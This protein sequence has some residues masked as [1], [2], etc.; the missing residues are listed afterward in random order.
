MGG[1]WGATGGRWEVEDA[2][3]NVDR[4]KQGINRTVILIKVKESSIP[5]PLPAKWKMMRLKDLGFPGLKDLD[6][7]NGRS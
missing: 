6:T 4:R 1:T 5:I 3:E 2:V 7:S